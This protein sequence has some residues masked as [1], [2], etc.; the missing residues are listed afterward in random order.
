LSTAIEPFKGLLLGLFFIAVGMSVNID[1]LWQEWWLVSL[2]VIGLISVKMAIMYGLARL[3]KVRSKARSR[4]ALILSQGGE[5]GFVILT[6]ATEGQL[7]TASQSALLVL[8]ISVSMMTTPLLLKLQTFYYSQTLN[9]PEEEPDNTIGHQTP[10]VIIAGFGRF[11][12]IVGRLMYAN[13]IKITVLESDASQIKLLRK[14]GY[15]VFYGDATHLELLR[16]A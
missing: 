7:F 4:S 1:L 5:I 12:Q 10:Q 13:K 8:V 16:S 11:G 14:Y 15:K 2:L 9:S 6:A 3:A